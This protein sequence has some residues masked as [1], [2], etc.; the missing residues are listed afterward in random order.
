MCP[1]PVWC[2]GQDVKFDCIGSWSLPFYLLYTKSKYCI[3][4]LKHN[5][6]CKFESLLINQRW[7]N[8][9]I[10]TFIQIS[11][12]TERQ[13]LFNVCCHRWLNSEL[14]AGLGYTVDT[15]SRATFI[16]FHV[17]YSIHWIIENEYVY[18]TIRDILWR[19]ISH[20]IVLNLSYKGLIFVIAPFLWLLFQIQSV[21]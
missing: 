18:L 11:F 12:S 5:W 7:Y 6:K 8:S 20:I 2:L 16:F 10:S 14:C 19:A 4:T 3:S 9:D 15:L 1:F 13:W 21:N 17:I